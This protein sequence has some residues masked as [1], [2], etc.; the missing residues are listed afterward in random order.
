M[1][2]YCPR[3][4]SARIQFDGINR[5]CCPDCG[6]V[7]FHNTAAAAGL[8]INTKQGFLFLIRGEEPA[9]GKLDVPGG[10]L[11][12]G[13]SALEGLRRE[14]REEIGRDCGDDI[15]FLASFPNIY[16]YK[17]IA[18]NTC[19]L[20]FTADMPD[21]TEND[22]TLQ[23]GEIGGCRFIRPE[24]IDLDQI[25]FPSARLAIQYTAGSER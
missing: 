24:N 16:E 18:Y 15:R 10:F 21:L 20:F 5:F 1:F 3:C 19:D 9:K 25:A 8:I 11:N 4:A 17:G 12:P 14:C 23:K 6:F 7:Y 22:L 13:E 2:R